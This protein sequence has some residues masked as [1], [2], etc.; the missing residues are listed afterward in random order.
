MTESGFSVG[1]TVGENLSE[2]RG[3]L[4]P[5]RIRPVWLASYPRSGNTFLRIVLQNFFRLPTYSIYN[6]EGQGFADP[7]AAALE[8]APVLPRNW[9]AAL[10]DE[11]GAKTILIKTH[12]RPEGEGPAIYLV[13][14]GRAAIDSYYYYHQKFAFEKPSRTE[15]IAGACQFGRWSDHYR[16][17]R[18][19]SRA[20]TLFLRYEDLV[21]QPEKW[22]PLLAEFLNQEPTNA[23]VP[24]FEELQRQFPVFFRRGRNEDFLSEWS[25]AQ[26]LLFNELHGDVMK[27]LGYLLTQPGDVNANTAAELAHSAAHWHDLYLEKLAS[28]GQTAATCQ[29]LN[30]ENERLAT[31]LRQLSEEVEPLRKSLWVKL[32]LA[33]GLLWRANKAKRRS[34]GPSLT[35]DATAP[36]QQARAN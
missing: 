31:E 5:R 20:N 3:T 18:P 23:R 16:A 2:A 32:G 11:V 4:F 25:P 6:I 14:D 15:V 22:I 12:D 34:A 26:M 24:T 30:K 1:G 9:R 10:S 7:S 13:R 8:E 28:L 33:L 29:Q 35:P 17:W 19:Q 36:R 27:E 21:S